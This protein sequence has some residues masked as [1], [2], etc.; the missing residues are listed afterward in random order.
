MLSYAF[1]AEFEKTRTRGVGGLQYITFLFSIVSYVPHGWQA[2]MD[3]DGRRQ[4]LAKLRGTPGI[5]EERVAEAERDLSDMQQRS[6]AA[7]D[8]YEVGKQERIGCGSLA[9]S[10]STFTPTFFVRAMQAI[11]QRMSGE[12]DRFQRERAAEMGYVLRDFSLA[13]ARVNGDT[14][15]LWGAFLG[16]LATAG[17]TA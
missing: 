7:K 13:Q 6:E 5:R 15:R 11:V 1:V 4:R 17:A 16:K 14:A 9:H 10:I 8:A 2:R 12:M 3:V